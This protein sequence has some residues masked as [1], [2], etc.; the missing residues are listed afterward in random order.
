VKVELIYDAD[1]PNVAAARAQL[2]KAFAATSIPA[3]WKEWRRDSPDAPARVKGFG[4]PTILLNGRDVLPMASNAPCCRVYRDSDG[5][6]AG[7]PA[8]ETITRALRASGTTFN[9]KSTGIWGPAIGIAFLPKL[10][11]P[12]CWPAY[13]ALVGALGMPFLFETTFLLPV[14]LGA[15]ALVLGLLAWKSSQ[16]RGHGPLLL[17]VCASVLLVAGKF[18]F[19]SN[20]AAYAGAGALFVAC[21]WN[22]W[23]NRS[24]EADTPCSACPPNTSS[25]INRSDS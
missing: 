21:V 9:W 18:G 15:L 4:S 22:S 17:G 13:A 19:G 3:R 16:R 5:R 11:C 8:L 7:V 25:P 14:T 24:S 6:I 23:P 10:V 20:A 12:A 2:L 1:C